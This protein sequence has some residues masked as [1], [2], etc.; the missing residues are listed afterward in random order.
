M[1][2]VGDRVKSVEVNDIIYFFSLD[3]GSYLHTLDNRNYVIDFTLDALV[4]LLDPERFY[5]INRKYIISFESIVEMIT[6]SGSKL[7]IELQ[8]S[9][10]D[11]I[12][13]SRERLSSF[14]EWI[15]K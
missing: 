10:D 6:L 13:I 9:E 12:Y 7:K 8:H 15:D 2:R 5:R 1:I 14:K 4:D 3:K 11:S